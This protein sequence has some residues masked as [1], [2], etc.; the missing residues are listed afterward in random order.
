LSA[1]IRVRIDPR[2]LRAFSDEI[3]KQVPF[4]LALTLTGLARRVEQEE[5]RN[6]L[7][8]MPTAT[9]FTVNSIRSRGATK[10]NLTA[11]VFVQDIAAQY[12]EP[13]ESGGTHF[14]GR[15]RGLL[16]PKKITVNQY[17]N[18][19]RNLLKQLKGRSDIFIGKVTT[20]SGRTINGVWQRPA[21]AAPT[22]PRKGKLAPNRTGALKL[23]I[24]FEDPQRVRQH[25]GFAERARLTVER[26]FAPEFE[27]AMKK[28][29]A[30]AK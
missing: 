1:E 27:A 22:R 26:F 30:S 16:V 23:L 2:S 9:P 8:V 6:L 5:K 12:L 17:G 25:L 3:K 10:A 21:A 15:K 29:V 18:L 13:F 11:R 28:A 4:A 24:R 14:L 19:P 7:A 20:R